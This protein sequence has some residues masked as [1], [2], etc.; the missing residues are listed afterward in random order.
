MG[1]GDLSDLNV[2]G[3]TSGDA[4]EQL[5]TSS[6]P[7]SAAITTTITT[8]TEIFPFFSHN[9]PG[10]L[11][12]E[13]EP[14]GFYTRANDTVLGADEDDGGQVTTNVLR[15]RCFN[16]GHEEHT[17]KECPIRH[18]Y[19]LIDLSRQYYKFTQE[20][21][22]SVPA[23]WQRVHI[24]EGWRQLRLDWVEDFEPGKIKGELLRDALGL[25]RNNDDDVDDGHAH[26]WLRNMAIWGYPKGWVSTRDPREL[27]RARIWREHGGDVET[28]FEDDTEPFVI[29]GDDGQHEEVLFCNTFIS[30]EVSAP[31]A[32][33]E[34]DT[35]ISHSQRKLDQQ[36]SDPG[37]ESEEDGRSLTDREDQDSQ[38]GPSS[39]AA[40]TTLSPIPASPD[41]TIT[42][43]ATKRWAQ[44]PSAYFLSDL[45]PVHTGFNLPPIINEWEDTPD[46]LAQAQPPPP[47]PMEPPPP[48][49]PPPPVEPPPPLPPPPYHAPPPLPPPGNSNTK[50]PPY[51]SW[52]PQFSHASAIPTTVL[53]SGS[54]SGPS[55]VG[56]GPSGERTDGNV[57]GVGM[58]SRRI[59]NDEIPDGSRDS[60]SEGSDME[61]S[62]SD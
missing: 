58:V 25:G 37:P 2:G 26:E 15:P 39:P 61:L 36:H 32:P 60:D 22:G 3:E 20:R 7:V 14:W 21:L 23:N 34:G 27:V 62:D 57:L 8:E 45:L 48:L 10:A 29:F 35:V 30:R 17:V 47:P 24:A 59:Q 49:P 1:Q 42:G 5:E 53:A 41:S 44:Y 56:N 6:V 4:Q 40:K 11:P 38:P 31:S 12:S 33:A 54:S 55:A 50:R 18:D 9:I 28:E 13:L 16:C 51:P 46:A 43:T 19:T 52:T